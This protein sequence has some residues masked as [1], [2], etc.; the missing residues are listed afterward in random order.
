MQLYILSPIVLYPLWRIRNNTKYAVAFIFVLAGLSVIYTFIAVIKNNL[1]SS[2]SFG[3]E[4][5]KFQ[6][7]VHCSTLARIDSWMMGILAGFTLHKLEE[8]VCILPR[9]LIY[10]G[11]IY[12]I[13]TILLV[14][15]GKYPLQQEYFMEIPWIFDVLFTSLSKIVFAMAIVWIIVACRT[16]N[17]GIVNKILSSNY[18]LPLSRLSYCIYLVHLAII[19]I[20]DASIRNPQYVSPFHTFH[21]FLGFSMMSIL[22]AFAWSLIFEY[23]TLNLIAYLTKRN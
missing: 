6:K 11:W 3:E 15:F 8:K 12:T 22:V 17:G 1:R 7:L 21:Q 23:P 9:K 18:F 2:Y 16:G 19:L 14:T 13:I 4:K 5:L 10:S 20:S